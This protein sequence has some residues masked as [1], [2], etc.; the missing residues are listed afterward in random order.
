[1]P[2]ESNDRLAVSSGLNS[3]LPY[4]KNLEIIF[5]R[6]TPPDKQQRSVEDREIADRK[7]GAA[8]RGSA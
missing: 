2:L 4:A 8:G 3:A 5:V 6:T 7:S 1:M